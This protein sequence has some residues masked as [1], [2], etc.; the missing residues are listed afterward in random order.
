M[1]DCL[2]QDVMSAYLDVLQIAADD[3][4]LR[5]WADPV[6]HIARMFGDQRLPVALLGSLQIDDDDAV[7][8]GVFVCAE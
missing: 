5:Y 3:L 1:P 4:V 8:G 6:E 2:I 7:V